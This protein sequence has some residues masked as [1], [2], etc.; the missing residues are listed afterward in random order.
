MSL[1]AVRSGTGKT[2]VELSGST[3]IAQ[4]DLSRLEQRESLDDVQV[5]TLRR[6]VEGLGGKLEVTAVFPHGHR[7]ILVG[8]PKER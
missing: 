4:G 3:A 6:Y 2:Q 5:G 7:I 8:A 1:R